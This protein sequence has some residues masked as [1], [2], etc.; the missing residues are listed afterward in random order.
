MERRSSSA[1]RETGETRVSVKVT[2]DGEGVF[3]GSTG[4]KFLDHLLSLL[5]YHS[6]VDLAVEAKWDLKHHCT[7]DVGIVL[8][9]A[10]GEAL[11]D[12]SG[13]A[14]FGYAIVPMDD[15]L[16][17]SSVDLVRRAHATINLSLSGSQVE[18]MVGEDIYH[19]FQSFAHSI[20]AVIHM[21]VRYGLNDHHKVEAAVKALSIALRSSWQREPRRR[22]PP[23]SKGVI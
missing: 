11:G 2:I 3:N 10:I 20:P 1:T 4:I 18:D 17:E 21:N 9:Q 8:G 5:A 22:G 23:S 15:A 12:R 14:R 16:A 7:E 13:I 6:I 19:F